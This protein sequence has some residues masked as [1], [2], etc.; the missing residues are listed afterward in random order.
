MVRIREAAEFL[1]V[2]PQCL[3]RW[4]REGRHCGRIHN[5]DANAAIN[6]KKVAE[7]S[8]GGCQ[9]FQRQSALFLREQE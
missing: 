8:V 2:A 4:E 1:G 7:S 5:R 9:P 6:L 3:R